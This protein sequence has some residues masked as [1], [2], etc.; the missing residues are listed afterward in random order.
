MS[1]PRANSSNTPVRDDD[2]NVLHANHR[3]QF[4]LQF[5]ESL[6][7]RL[8]TRYNGIRTCKFHKRHGL[9]ARDQMLTVTDGF[10]YSIET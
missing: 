10:K 7:K 6:N 2:D 1:P 3:I 8:L 4:R 9:K 5:I